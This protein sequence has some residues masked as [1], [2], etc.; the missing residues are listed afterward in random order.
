MGEVTEDIPLVDRNSIAGFL[1]V[2]NG[3]VKRIRDE[4]IG[5]RKANPLAER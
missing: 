3:K 5:I 2:Y 4:C 1:V